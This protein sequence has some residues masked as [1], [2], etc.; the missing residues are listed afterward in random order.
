MNYLHRKKLAFMSIVNQVKGFV[1]TISGVPPITLESCVD[2]KSVINYQIYGNSVQDGEP[3]PDN[4]VEVVSVG[5]KTS[6]LFDV[7]TSKGLQSQYGGITSNV[8]GGKIIVNVTTN[9][10]ANLK[11]GTFKAGT[12]TAS[13]D[14]FITNNGGNTSFY[15]LMT[16]ESISSLTTF[17]DGLGGKKSVTFTLTEEQTV[18]FFHSGLNT[19]NAPYTLSGVQVVEGN[20]AKEYEPFGY[21]I[22]ITASGKNL[23]NEDLF[24]DESYWTFN[25]NGDIGFFYLN[26]IGLEEGKQYTILTNFVKPNENNLGLSIYRGDT[27]ISTL[28]NGTIS[29]T[30]QSDIYLRIYIPNKNGAKLNFHKVREYYQVMIVEGSYTLDTIGDYEPYHEPVTT[31]IYLNEPLAQGQTIN[32]KEDNL[33]DLPTFKGTTIY[34]IDT[35]V[36]PTNMEVT[37]YST[38]KE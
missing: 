30:Y 5:D 3:T 10:S 33:P 25:T 22:P 27:Y 12:Y 29:F 9:R 34:T 8:E 21:K 1:R 6:N 2:D 7:S 36:Q 38:V 19:A 15:R 18:W 26:Q 13:F 11:L 20:V 32:Y 31:N 17:I 16:G 4:P 24:L 28:R 23:L 35:T 14:E 37:Y